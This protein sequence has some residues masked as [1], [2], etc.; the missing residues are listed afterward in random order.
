MKRIILLICMVFYSCLAF[1][2]GGA[3]LV[4]ATETKDF[5]HAFGWVFTFNFFVPT[6]FLLPFLKKR[7]IHL[8]FPLELLIS[9]WI[10]YLIIRYYYLSNVNEISLALACIIPGLL[11]YMYSIIYTKNTRKTNTI[12]QKRDIARIRI[13]KRYVVSNLFH[14]IFVPFVAIYVYFISKTPRQK[15]KKRF[16]K[17]GWDVDNPEKFA[18]HLI[19]HR[20]KNPLLTCAVT[21]NWKR[22]P[23]NQARSLG[24]LPLET[25]HEIELLLEFL[26]IDFAK[27][28]EKEKLLV[29]EPLIVIGKRTYTPAS[30]LSRIE[31]KTPLGIRFLRKHTTKAMEST[32]QQRKTH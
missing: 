29:N 18:K 26:K 16:R 13:F 32:F 21:L 27:L 2:Q 22:I 7:I 9:T 8:L 28:C 23:I 15:R 12:K 25:Q 1:S 19:L 14:S 6:S 5:W 20:R 11:M 17:L 30:M 31:R 10:G 3:I 24:T 4:S